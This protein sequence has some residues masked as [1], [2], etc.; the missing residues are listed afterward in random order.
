MKTFGI[1]CVALMSTMA[2]QPARAQWAV[3]D[4]ANLA[5]ALNTARNTLAQ[6]EEAKRMYD[7]VNQLTDISSVA[8]VLNSSA[9]RGAL[10]PELRNISDD[11]SQMG[12]I[13]QRAQALFQQG[14][15]S[16]GGPGSALISALAT[17]GKRAARDRAIAEQALD[18]GTARAD[19]L[20]AL[21]SRLGTASTG[22]EAADLSARASIE[23]ASA[24]NETNRLLALQMQQQAEREQNMAEDAAQRA[25]DNKAQ[26]A[27]LR[28]IL[29]GSSGQ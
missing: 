10:P 24:V 14:N 22:K 15:Y 4:S 23:T 12:A 26:G 27:A 5:Q 2:A 3:I 7:S 9:L 25:R 19:G 13:G 18:N 1:V 6:I 8:S 21:A 16:S 11:I 29:Y 17:L 28:T 20:N